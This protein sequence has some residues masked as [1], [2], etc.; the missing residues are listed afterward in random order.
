[1]QSNKRVIDMKKPNCYSCIHRRDLIG[2]CHSSCSNHKANV[3]ANRHGI[4]NGWFQWPLNFDPTWL[5]AC[6][7]YEEIKSKAIKES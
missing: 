7:G 5:T 3:S 2:N 6:D 1:M 4:N